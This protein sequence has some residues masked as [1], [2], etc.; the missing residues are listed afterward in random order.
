MPRGFRL[1]LCG[2]GI[3]ALQVH[4]RIVNGPRAETER[5]AAMSASQHRAGAH[6]LAFAMGATGCIAPPN[7]MA[8]N[9]RIAVA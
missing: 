4:R 8:I 6:G 1:S 5:L 9:V 7:N 2:G 3:V